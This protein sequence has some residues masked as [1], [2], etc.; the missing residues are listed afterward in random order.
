MNQPTR[1]IDLYAAVHKGLRA[2]M[3]HVLVEA[4][5][6]DTTDAEDTTRTLESVRHLLLLC[7][8]HLEHEDTFL[9]GAMEARRPGSAAE[10]L[11]DHAGH[12][13]AFVDIENAVRA[14]EEAEAHA[15]PFAAR[16]LYALLARFVADNYEHMHVEE[17]HNNAG[18]HHEGLR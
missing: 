7:R 10:T 14:V 1:R 6:M 15:R 5:R 8:S 13:Q 17:T 12:K 9:H 4:G 11:G 16:R 2:C 18:S 3:A